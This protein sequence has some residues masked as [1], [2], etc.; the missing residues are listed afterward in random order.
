MIDK[1]KIIYLLNHSIIS[2]LIIAKKQTYANSDSP[3]VNPS[4]LGSKDYE[5]SEEIEGTL[6][7][8]HD[9]YFGGLNFIGEEVIYIG[10]NT[11]KWGM[12]YYGNTICESISEEV[13]DKV[14]RP[15]LMMVG[16][17]KKVIPV[18]GP[19]KFKTDEYTYTFKTKGTIENFV[20]TEEI[21]KGEELIYCLQCQ[22]GIIN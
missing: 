6:M 16:E 1:Q 12:N 21:Y 18:R 3:K 9:T 10:K 15:A 22:G 7:S 14:L 17:D 20:G 11:P 2:F 4:R 5:F 8:Y 19:S 13:M